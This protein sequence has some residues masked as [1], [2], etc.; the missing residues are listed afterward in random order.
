MIST[1]L[2]EENNFMEWPCHTIDAMPKIDK[3]PNTPLTQ[4]NLWHIPTQC[5]LSSILLEIQGL[6]SY[7]GHFQRTLYQ[8]LKHNDP[9]M[10]PYL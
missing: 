1:H 3:K 2:L 4:D 7:G 6:K 5:S 8:R 9:F 10:I